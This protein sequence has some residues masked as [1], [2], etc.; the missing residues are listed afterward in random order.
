MVTLSVKPNFARL[1]S[2]IGNEIKS[3]SQT[4]SQLS[5]AEINQLQQKKQFEIL[6]HT[7]SKEDIIIHR[8]PRVESNTFLTGQNVS[9]QVNPNLDAK[10]LEEGLMREV[11]RRIQITRK[12]AQLNL[13]DRISLQLQCNKETQS[14]IETHLDF[15]CAETLATSITFPTQLEKSTFIKKFEL[16][17]AQLIISIIRI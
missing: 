10:Q 9:I 7:L 16:E 17:H 15:V 6:G 11:V 3:M 14:A 2:R 1:G 8:H 12:E 13:N 4:L 5:P